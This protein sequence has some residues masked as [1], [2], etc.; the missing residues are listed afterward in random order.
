MALDGTFSGL[1]ASIADLLNRTDLTAAIPD[2]ITLA[3]AQMARRF[4]SRIKDGLPV[5]RRLVSTTS[6]SISSSAEYED[7]PDD[8]QGPLTFEI[9]TSPTTTELDYL[10]NANLQRWKTDQWLRASGAPKWYTVVGSQFQLFPVA[11][12]A[13]TAQLI[14]IA[15]IAAL[16]DAAPTNWVLADYP[17]AYLYGA[18]LA[19]APYLK[20]DGRAQMWG[21]LFS[22]ALDDICNADPMPTDKS[23]LR[24][25]I[26]T[27][28]RLSRGAT[29]YYNINTDNL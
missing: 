29:G 9:N 16:S 3:E 2:F 19:S 27:I 21:T 17:D 7:V 23:T 12:Q 18:A 11:D 24:T 13:Y 6:I 10:D 1:K 22:T 20:D 26:A 14:Y 28:Q 15:R 5:P 8:F 4:V 25:E